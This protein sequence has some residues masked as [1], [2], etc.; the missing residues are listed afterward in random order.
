M[1]KFF[2][3]IDDTN[4]RITINAEKIA[5]V[6]PSWEGASCILF[7]NDKTQIVKVPYSDLVARLGTCKQD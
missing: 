7:D 6:M 5:M 4:R 1:T 2:E 3:V